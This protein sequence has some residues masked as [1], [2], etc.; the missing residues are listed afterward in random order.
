MYLQSEISFNMITLLFLCNI[1]AASYHPSQQCA[2]P[3]PSILD[4]INVNSQ[5]YTE[6]RIP[7][8]NCRFRPKLSLGSLGSHAEQGGSSS[9]FL[10]LLKISTSL[11]SGSYLSTFEIIK[12][13]SEWMNLWILIKLCSKMYIQ[14]SLIWDHGPRPPPALLP[15]DP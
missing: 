11:V 12:S 6:L 4:R 15:Y 3:S 14:F 8:S 9:S 13:K 1:L 5:K 7:H 2:E 10:G